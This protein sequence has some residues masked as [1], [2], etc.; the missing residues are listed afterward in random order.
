MRGP[1]TENRGAA[2]SHRGEAEIRWTASFPLPKGF[3]LWILRRGRLESSSL[4]RFQRASREIDCRQDG[5]RCFLRFQLLIL[6]R[7]TAYLLGRLRLGTG[8]RCFPRFLPSRGRISPQNYIL[9]SQFSLGSIEDGGLDRAQVP[10]Q[11][12]RGGID[13]GVGTDQELRYNSKLS[14]LIIAHPVSFL[15][16]NVIVNNRLGCG[17]FAPCRNI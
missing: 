10:F 5:R 3:H 14:R 1:P 7:I 15:R 16:R 12:M 13:V 9:S 2:R 8:F 4:C 17:N 6:C 11:L